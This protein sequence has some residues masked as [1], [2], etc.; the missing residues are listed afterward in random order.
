MDKA[1]E[2]IGEWK[3]AFGQQSG[4]KAVNDMFSELQRQGYHIPEAEVASAAFLK[5]APEWVLGDRCYMCR[6][7]FH[8]FKGAFRVRASLLFPFSIESVSIAVYLNFNPFSTTVVTAERVC[9]LRVPVNV[10]PCLTTALSS[11]PE[12]VTSATRNRTNRKLNNA[13]ESHMT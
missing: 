11:Q 6:N 5:K 8:R 13:H 4:Y 9:V 1:L 10:L 7:E 3:A 2:M 12:S